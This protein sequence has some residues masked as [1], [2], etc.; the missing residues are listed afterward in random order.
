MLTQKKTSS[1][2][3]LKGCC[4]GHIC[5]QASINLWPCFIPFLTSYSRENL[6]TAEGK[7]QMAAL[8]SE[9]FDSKMG[10]WCEMMTVIVCRRAKRVYMVFHLEVII[11]SLQI[12][13][14]QWWSLVGLLLDIN[15]VVS[16]HTH[17]YTNCTCC[18]PCSSSRILSGLTSLQEIN[19]PIKNAIKILD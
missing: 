4:N 11:Y 14:D 5:S 19:N 17:K 15:R 16:T 10:K 12:I 2:L 18:L 7:W 13:K 3:K 1:K 6:A 9:G 8:L